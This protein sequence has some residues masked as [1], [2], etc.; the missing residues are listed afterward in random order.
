[1]ILLGSAMTPEER[2]RKKD[3]QGLRY[4]APKF[5]VGLDGSLND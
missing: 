3:Q 1:M 2:Q 5:V 4:G